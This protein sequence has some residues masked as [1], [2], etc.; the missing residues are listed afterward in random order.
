MAFCYLKVTLVHSIWKLQKQ[1]HYQTSTNN[2]RTT[3][4]KDK[5]R[6]IENNQLA[7]FEEFVKHANTRINIGKN[8][9]PKPPK[10]DKHI[11]ILDTSAEAST[12]R[13]PKRQKTD[14]SLPNEYS[15]L[16][17]NLNE[18]GTR[19]VTAGISKTNRPPLDSPTPLTAVEFRNIISELKE[20]QT[21]MLASLKSSGL[22]Q[23]RNHGVLKASLD[24]LFSQIKDLM[25]ENASLRSDLLALKKRVA[26]LETPAVNSPSHDA[27]CVPQL[28]AKLSERQKCS[29]NVVVH[30][31]PESSTTKPSDKIA[32]DSGLLSEMILPLTLTLPPNLKLFRLGRPNAKRPRLLKINFPSKESALQFV[33]DFNTNKRSSSDHLPTILVVRDR[34]LAERL[35]IRR[36]YAELEARKKNG[37][38]EVTVRLLIGTVYLPPSSPLPL[39]EA[40]TSS[41]EIVISSVNPTYTL[42]CGDFNLPHIDWSSTISHLGLTASG[43]LSATSS[44]LV[45]TFSFLNFFQ[46]NQVHNTHGGLLDLVF[47]TSDKPSVTSA[48]SPLV[49]PDSFHPPLCI[50]FPIE[51][52]DPQ[53]AVYPF[54]DF[55]SGNYTAMSH[56]LG[57]F[58]WEATF[59]PL[60]LEESALLFNNALLN[61]IDKYL[62]YSDHCAY[63]KQ[64]EDALASTPSRFWSYVK[65]LKQ[66]PSIPSVV[67]LNNVSSSS[68]TESANLFASY[69]SSTYNHSPPT[70]HSESPSPSQFLFDLPSNINFPSKDVYHLLGSLV[71]SFSIGPDGISA[72]C[73]YNCRHSITNP[74]FQLFRRSLSEGIFPTNWKFC[75]VTPVLKAGDPSDV[76]NYSPISIILHSAKLFESLVY[77]NIKRSLNHIIIDEQYGFRPGKSTVTSSVAFTTYLIDNIEK[78]GKVDVVFTDFKKAFDTVD[79][80]LLINELDTLGIDDP[81]LSWLRSYL[82]NRQQFAKVNNYMVFNSKYD[83]FITRSDEYV[84]PKDCYHPTSVCEMVL[85]PVPNNSE[86]NHLPFQ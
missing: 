41:V 49:N 53:P 81:L 36:I 35:E 63:I 37:E 28:L 7:D 68:D 48:L 15:K 8:Y 77:S 19:S 47:S 38:L 14:G 31:L 24:T 21:Q 51:F 84:V 45:D 50:Q 30:G 67:H 80:G 61:A 86:L 52:Y 66:V 56:Y 46:L 69:F 60:S 34:T 83:I 40:Y 3:K 9:V 11:P 75:S 76:T 39:Y 54:C 73:L 71:N 22:S 1:L 85:A 74:V 33:R 82:S 42:L 78:G 26:V 2:Y 43:N 32:D 13:E 25:S 4:Q 10:P 44:H 72:R 59:S 27:G 18:S 20:A 5:E 55:K 17:F 57:S 23:D 29:F 16:I 6:V 79:H 62:S 65:S 70:L 12:S 58:N 64:T